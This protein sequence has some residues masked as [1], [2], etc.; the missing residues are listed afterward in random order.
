M[1][2]NAEKP[3]MGK[4]DRIRVFMVSGLTFR[5]LQGGTFLWSKTGTHIY[6]V[7]LAGRGS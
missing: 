3:C 1:D 2:V 4:E 7:L 6:F 5:A